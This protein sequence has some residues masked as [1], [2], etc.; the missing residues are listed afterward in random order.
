MQLLRALFGIS[1]QESEK[2][3][4]K[5]IAGTLILL[6]E[7]FKD[8]L[9]IW[10]DFL[11]VTDPQ[12]PVIKAD[13]EERQHK[14]F[15]L[16]QSLIRSMSRREPLIILVDDLHWFDPSGDAFITRG[17]DAVKDTP[18]LLLLNYRPEYRRHW[19]NKSIK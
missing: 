6:G 9:P 2:E 18:T 10:F 15:A 8:T 16:I 11:T 17:V 19:M 4:R 13:S 12:Q 14:L 1:D 7:A 3:T 5:K